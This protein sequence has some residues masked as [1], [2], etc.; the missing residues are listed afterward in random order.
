MGV[1]CNFLMV[2][3]GPRGERQGITERSDVIPHTTTPALANRHF[4]SRGCYPPPK[5]PSCEGD[6]VTCRKELQVIISQVQ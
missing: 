5:S 2:C 3:K 1:L 4:A 6:L